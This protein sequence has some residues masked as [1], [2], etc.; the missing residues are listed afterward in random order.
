[1]HDLVQV[2]QVDGMLKTE[3]LRQV[4]GV[5]FSTRVS[6]DYREFNAY[7]TISTL[8]ELFVLFQVPPFII[9][10][11]ALHCLGALSQVYRHA[12]S[13]RL[14]IYSHFHCGIARM[15]LAEI[16]FHGLLGSSRQEGLTGQG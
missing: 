4:H 16:G 8:L 12:R 3:R 6:G 2:P 13:T 11:V 5:L 1:M 10:L 14:N 7:A 9:R 15:L